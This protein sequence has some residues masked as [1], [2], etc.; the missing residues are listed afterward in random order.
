MLAPSSQH[1]HHCIT[2]YLFLFLTSSSMMQVV[3]LYFQLQL[4]FTA[5]YPLSS[6]TIVHPSPV[7]SVFQGEAAN[8][9]AKPSTQF[10]Y[11][12]VRG[13][14]D[15][16]GNIPS[17]RPSLKGEARVFLYSA[18]SKCLTHCENGSRTYTEAAPGRSLA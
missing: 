17:L 5:L 10:Q 15:I 12:G 18:Y 4:L 1:P 2:S 16:L 13:M 11:L 3:I 14:G 8:L 7:P 6:G 9:Q